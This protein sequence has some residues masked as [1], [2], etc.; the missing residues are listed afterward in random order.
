MGRNQALF[1]SK[2]IRDTAAENESRHYGNFTGG[3]IYPF[4]TL[5]YFI[6]EFDSQPTVS[7]FSASKLKTFIN[8][9]YENAPRY[10]PG[11]SQSFVQL[12]IAMNK[13]WDEFTSS[14]GLPV[15]RRIAEMCVRIDVDRAV[16][17]SPPAPPHPA[18]VVVPDLAED[19][20]FAEEPAQGSSLAD[21]KKCRVEDYEE[22][23]FEETEEDT[24]NDTDVEEETVD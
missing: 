12:L 8:S 20:W 11:S 17:I 1:S 19:S 24:V 18:P 16:V 2:T 14:Y 13:S 22:E 21:S 5:H 15:A 3:R 7:E 9:C 6:D 23:N 4:T 10:V